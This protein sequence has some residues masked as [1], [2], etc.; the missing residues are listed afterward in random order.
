MSAETHR[1]PAGAVVTGAGRGL[2]RQ[3][4]GL[5]MERGYR[6][7]VTDLD[8]GGAAGGARARRASD[9]SRARRP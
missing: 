1:W 4:A 2:G 5:L 8:G 6:V 9:S 7:L 3:I